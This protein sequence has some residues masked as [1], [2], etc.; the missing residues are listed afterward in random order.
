MKKTVK[1]EITVGVFVILAAVILG[2]ISLKISGVH[3][4]DGINVN[5]V[6]EHACGLVKDSAV[7]MAGVEI[8]YVK[9]IK[10]KNDK[11]LVTARIESSAKLRTN[12]SATIRTKGLL[13][14]EY[15][16]IIPGNGAAPL[17]KNGDTITDTWIPVQIDQT[18]AWAGSVLKE[19]DPMDAA[20]IMKALSEDPDAVRRILQNS[21]TLLNKLV[22]MDKEEIKEFIDQVSIKARLF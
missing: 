19:I 21:D 3:V 18:F 7:S 4:R 10:L 20:R 2:F 9:A 11:A 14:E 12:T 13:G 5:F 16:E 6:F 1:Y 22:N 8:G 15:L 17:L